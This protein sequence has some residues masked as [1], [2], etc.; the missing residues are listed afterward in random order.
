MG[1]ERKEGFDGLVRLVRGRISL[2]RN[3]RLRAALSEGGDPFQR[4]SEELLAAVVIEWTKDRP[5]GSPPA[6]AEDLSP[7]E[8][9][10][11]T[12]RVARRLERQADEGTR[13]LAPSGG[14][15]GISTRT[16]Y[17]R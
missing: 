1:Q 11:L 6:S 13:W 4:L 3:K 7:R 10:S 14:S 15:P 2:T 12:N 17:P 8:L 5:D 9:G 16:K